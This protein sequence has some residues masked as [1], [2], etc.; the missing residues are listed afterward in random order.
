MRSLPGSANAVPANHCRSHM[1]HILGPHRAGAPKGNLNA[2]KT[3]R[4]AQPA[5][6][7]QFSQAESAQPNPHQAAEILSGHIT[8]I[9]DRTGDA[10]LTLLLLARLTEQLLP[11]V[12]DHRFHL[13]LSRFLNSLPPAS[14]P[15]MEKTVWKYAAPYNPF[16]RLTL[17][18]GI[19]NG[20]PP[21]N[22]Q[23]E[24]NP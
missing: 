11:L 3:G 13:E 14:R 24:S 21:D 5:W 9:Q 17:L 19:I 23:Q 16:D 18:R 20:I 2:V 10:Y 4:F 22:N 15:S 1:D 12:A 7:T 6:R 8:R